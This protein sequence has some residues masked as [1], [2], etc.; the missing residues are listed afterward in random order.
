VT[1]WLGLALL[2][3]EMV[4]ALRNSWRMLMRRLLRKTSEPRE[5]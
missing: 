4:D 2:G 5:N 3:K 1:G